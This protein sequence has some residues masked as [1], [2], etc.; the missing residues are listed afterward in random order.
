MA[1][2]EKRECGHPKSGPFASPCEGPLW[3]APR[4]FA[5]GRSSFKCE[6]HALFAMRANPAGPSFSSP[7]DIAAGRGGDV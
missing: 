7:A 6:K 5:N 1:A 3:E 2:E 4:Y